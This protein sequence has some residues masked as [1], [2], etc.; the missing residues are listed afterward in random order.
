MHSD[1]DD[2]TAA[3]AGPARVSEADGE[4]PEAPIVTAQHALVLL[5]GME[6]MLRSIVRDV[7]AAR[8]RVVVET[9]I[10]RDDRLGRAFGDALARAVARGVSVR[11][12]YDPLGSQKTDPAFFDSLRGCGLDVRPYR[13]RDV[14]VRTMSYGPRDHSR[15]IVVDGAAYTGGAAW[16]DEWLPAHRGGKGWHD[17][18]LRVEGPVVEDF[19][20]VFDARWREAVGEIAEPGDY[21]TND[22]YPDLEFVCDAPTGATRVY[23]RYCAAIER[24]RS[25]VWLENAYFFPPPEMLKALYDAAARGVDVRILLPDER[26]DLPIMRRAAR[27]EFLEW[28][29]RGLKLYE[30]TRCMLHSKFAVIDDDWCTVGTFNAS[31]PGIGWANEANVFVYDPAF[32]ARC[33]RLFEADLAHCEPIAAEDVRARPLLQQAGDQLARDAMT[34]LDIAR[35]SGK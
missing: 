19:L 22:K 21:A 26:T 12:L 29:D 32:V 1:T 6:P 24:A 3:C 14:V 23:G 35:T 2:P 15:I 27:A 18:C 31:A 11:L 25:R 9:Y 20:G 5:P 34:I 4:E 13:P 7:D 8:E 28:I 16:G 33:A 10:Y 17:V 30:Y